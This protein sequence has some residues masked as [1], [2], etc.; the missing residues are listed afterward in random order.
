MDVRRGASQAEAKARRGAEQPELQQRG[1]EAQDA[2]A[3]RHLGRPLGAAPRGRGPPGEAQ[4]V[5]TV[6]DLGGLRAALATRPG[7]SA[8]GGWRH[9]GDEA[10]ED[11]LGLV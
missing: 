4:V 6:A 3:Q 10:L 7:H 9:A 5:D 11:L 8:M 2:K 1:Q